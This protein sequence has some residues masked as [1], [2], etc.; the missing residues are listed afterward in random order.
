MEKHTVGMNKYIV[1]IANSCND[2]INHIAEYIETTFSDPDTANRI[3][4]G[5]YA[6]IANLS[7]LASSFDYCDDRKLAEAGIRKYYIGTY[8]IYYE[9]VENNVVNVLRVRHELQDENKFF[10]IKD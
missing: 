5:I 6:K 8:F 4:L 2:D 9:I 10:D 1:N 7:Y 3:S